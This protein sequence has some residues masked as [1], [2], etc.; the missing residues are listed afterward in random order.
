MKNR[1]SVLI[2]LVLLAILTSLPLA[3]NAQNGSIMTKNADG[4]TIT[5]WGWDTLD[6]NKPVLA[7]L[8]DHS[9][10]SVND[11]VYPHDDILQKL[12]VSAAAGG[13][14]MPDVFKLTS[15][16][17]PQLVEMGAVKDITDLVAPYK[18]LLPDV[19]WQMVTYNG[20]IWGVPANS[21]AGGMFWR[22]DVVSQYG[23]DPTKIA[24]WADFIAAAQKLETASGG[25]VAMIQTSSVGLPWPIDST[26]QQEH[27][28]ELI[29]NDMK[30]KIGPNSAEWLATLKDWRAVKDGI[31]GAEMDQWSQPWYQAIKDGSIAVFPSGTW[32]VETIIQ[33][34]PDS[35][36]KWF[37]TPFPAVEAGGDQYPNFGS[38]TC[39]I[40]SASKDPTAGMEWVKAWTMEP[41]STLSIGLKQLGISVISKAALTDSYVNAPHEYFAANQAYWKDATLA[42][43]K[44]T[45]VPPMTKFDAQA[46][47][48]FNRYAEQWWKKQITDQQFLQSVSDELTK[49][50]NG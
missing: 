25:K 20:K 36:G 35:K 47:D 30:V 17:I 50:V 29:G 21:P 23:I 13:A 9:G 16:N 1:F 27:K 7:Y 19:A 34:A 42:F 41:D 32:F 39:F 37:F 33:Q 8:K 44:S 12:T 24:T 46:N 28:A 14:G 48:I 49:L 43:S 3:V 26:I 10:V 11:Q 15:T 6:F 22:S 31:K 40:S 18:A 38:A 5:A 4:H 2:A 45:Y